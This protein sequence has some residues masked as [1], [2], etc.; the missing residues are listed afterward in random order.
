M[1]TNRKRP[2]V[3]PSAIDE[4]RRRNIG[5]SVNVLVQLGRKRLD[6]DYT[7][8]TKVLS[9]AG[10]FTTGDLQKELDECAIARNRTDQR[11]LGRLDHLGGADQVIRL[12]SIL[13]VIDVVR[14]RK[15]GWLARCVQY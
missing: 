5:Q 3:Y 11:L 10:D 4:R 8:E 9:H 13:P 14:L 12:K 6:G 1:S 15:R 7:D 2:A